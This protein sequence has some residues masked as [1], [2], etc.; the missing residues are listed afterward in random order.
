MRVN[1]SVARLVGAVVF[2]VLWGSLGP[3][4]RIASASGDIGMVVGQFLGC[5]KYKDPGAKVNYSTGITGPS[6]QT[7][8]GLCTIK[9]PPK[10]ACYTAVHGGI[11][12]TPPGGGPTTPVSGFFCYAVK[13]KGKGTIVDAGK[14]E[15]GSHSI[16]TGKPVAPTMFCAPASPSGAFLD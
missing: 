13:C 3:V 12:P 2:T 9:F 11:T 10:L 7:A 4:T 16:V 15:L 8:W 1:G 14:D 6:P 5:V